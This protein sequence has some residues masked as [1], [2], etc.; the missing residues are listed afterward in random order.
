[1]DIDQSATSSLRLANA[2]LADHPGRIPAAAG[3]VPRE[4]AQGRRPH[5]QHPPD[6][7][8]PIVRVRRPLMSSLA[9]RYRLT[10]L[11]VTSLI[12]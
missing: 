1:M 11:M 8:K 6:M 7:G 4:Q 2:V 9:P 10:W 5:C 3:D 12:R